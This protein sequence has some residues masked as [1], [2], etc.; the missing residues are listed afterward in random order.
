MQKE[1]RRDTQ[2]APACFAGRIETQD[3][4]SYRYYCGLARNLVP[5]SA[6]ESQVDIHKGDLALVNVAPFIGA[7]M[8]GSESISCEALDGNGTQAHVRAEPPYR[9]VSLW[10][11]SNWIDGRQRQKRELLS[12]LCIA[13]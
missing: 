3:S 12:S 10:L 6:G 13:D 4:A 1:R 7:V 2:I 5:T 9:G 11:L 8:R